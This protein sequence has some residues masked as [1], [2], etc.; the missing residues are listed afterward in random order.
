MRLTIGQYSVSGDNENSL[1][2]D[3]ESSRRKWVTRHL[4]DKQARVAQQVLLGMAEFCDQLAVLG[5]RRNNITRPTH[6]SILSPSRHSRMA[7][8]AL[9]RD[10][11][12]DVVVLTNFI[13]AGGGKTIR[14]QPAR[15]SD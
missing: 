4:P 8:L 10:Q 13:E 3:N 5:S 1:F 6:I 11:F 7:L 14:E 9:R 15:H 12:K 2:S